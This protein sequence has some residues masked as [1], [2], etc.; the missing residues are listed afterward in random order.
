VGEEGGNRVRSSRSVEVVVR[1][2]LGPGAV[3]QAALGPEVVRWAA[4]GPEVVGGE[5]LEEWHD[6]GSPVSTVGMVVQSMNG[7]VVRSK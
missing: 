1:S 3:T 6:V 5:G 4:R 2:A 7:V